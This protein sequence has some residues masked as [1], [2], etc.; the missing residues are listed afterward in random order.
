MKDIN[1]PYCD[2][3]LDIDHDDGFGYEQD[4][5]HE[6]Q[7]SNCE[8]IFTFTTYITFNYETFTADCLNGGEHIFVNSLGK[9]DVGAK[10]CSPPLRQSAVNV[11]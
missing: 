9:V 5:L 10:I 7:C 6:Q 4:K 1:C 8:K 11:S 3:E 2:A